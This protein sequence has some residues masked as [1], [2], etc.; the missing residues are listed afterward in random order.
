[1][2]PAKFRNGIGA[3]YG[4]P[5]KTSF[6]MTSSQ[7]VHL[8]VK[9]SLCQICSRSEEKFLTCVTFTCNFLGRGEPGAW[10]IGLWIRKDNRCDPSVP[11]KNRGVYLIVKSVEPKVLWSVASSAVRSLHQWPYVQRSEK[12]Y[13]SSKSM[14]CV[15]NRT[16]DWRSQRVRALLRK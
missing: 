7:F 14:N 11:P 5:C 2:A 15:T 6:F 1:M 16:F 8:N 12:I 13:F 9:T 3:L 4:L 10:I